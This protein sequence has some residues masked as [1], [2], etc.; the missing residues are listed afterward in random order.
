[1]PSYSLTLRQNKGRRLTISELDNNWLYLKELAELGG[2]SSDSSGDFPIREYGVSYVGY[3]ISDLSYVGVV[4][5]IS[6]SFASGDT[7]SGSSSGATADI[8]HILDDEN[9]IL[10]VN[11]VSGTF[12]Q[13]YINNET[14]PGVGEFI[15]FN[16]DFDYGELL[17]S[18][19]GQGRNYG[20]LIWATGSTINDL[21]LFIATTYSL[22]Q[23]DILIQGEDN[24]LT[25]LG[26]IS[27]TQ[28][29]LSS[30]YLT[31]IE[32]DDNLFG[33]G[34]QGTGVIIQEQSSGNTSFVGVVNLNIPQFITDP[35]MPSILN[36]GGGNTNYNFF[37]RTGTYFS[38]VDGN[39]T[40]STVNISLSSVCIS[41]S[42][43]NCCNST[44]Y[45]SLEVTC[46]GAGW[47][48]NNNHFILPKTSPNSCGQP[49]VSIGYGCG[50]IELGWGP[51][52][53]SGGGSIDGLLI[54]DSITKVGLS[55]GNCGDS[56][57]FIGESSGQNLSTGDCNIFI[58]YCSAQ[59]TTSISDSILIGYLAGIS[60]CGSNNVF[61]GNNTGLSTCGS[62]NIFIGNRSGYLNN[63]GTCNIYIGSN[64][65]Y[66]N[67]TGYNNVFI[68]K[69]SGCASSLVDEGTFI[70]AL[71]GF[72]NCGIRNTFIGSQAGYS[73]QGC[74]NTTMGNESGYASNG[75]SNIFIGLNS[76]YY[77]TG[78]FNTHIGVNAGFYC[79]GNICNTIA[80]GAHSQP[81]L[82]GDFAI[83]STLAQISAGTTAYDG[84]VLTTVTNYLCV[85]IN[86]TRYKLALFE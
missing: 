36:F 20:N 1:M 28:S 68:G 48:S 33:S 9:Q 30:T 22:S 69:D 46:C 59:S 26:V 77:F 23:Y 24:N 44:E 43:T 74:L 32:S 47:G 72:N 70:G 71:S 42:Y 10:F 31:G 13:E 65:G 8:I 73:S 80:L 25:V 15:L 14:Q 76:G 4:D 66:N 39:N 18:S 49:I 52:Y 86:G 40:G 55:S 11:N 84:G 38:F 16:T 78:C 53:G 79:C 45:N 61:I 34:N 81:E 37:S 50:T 85:I 54:G 67:T 7:I 21:S 82:D 5:L 6:G 17:I 12:S 35:M 41:N 83:G 64:V 3:L 2:T 75:C 29:E 27:A 63:V 56:N 19:D 51:T 60:A 62:D 57:I 58:G